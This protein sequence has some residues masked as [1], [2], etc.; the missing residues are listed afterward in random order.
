MDRQGGNRSAADLAY[1]VISERILNG[2]LKPGQRLTRREMAALTGVSIIPVI[3]ALHR[4]ENEG[5]VQS[6]PYVGSSVI[7]LT[8]EVKLDRYALRLAAECQVAR[9]LAHGE[10]RDD[11]KHQL[12]VQARALDNQLEINERSKATWEMHYEFHVGLA[13]L[14]ECPSLVDAL[15]RN[16]LFLLLEWQKLSRWK[17]PSDNRDEEAKSHLWFLREIFAG[18]PSRAEL[19][20]RRHISSVAEFPSELSDLE[21]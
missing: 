4:L 3:D 17:Q 7:S 8:A 18:S 6:I 9:M 15:R 1:M 5:L 20:V 16:H 19:A 21:I 14:T 11:L 13:R 10:L 12:V 2:E